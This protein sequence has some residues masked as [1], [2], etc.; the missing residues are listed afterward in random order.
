M[1][2]VQQCDGDVWL[3]QHHKPDAGLYSSAGVGQHIAADET[4]ADDNISSSA[5]RITTVTRFD[6]SLP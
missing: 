3:M 5:A 1:A 2:S 6:V 4:V